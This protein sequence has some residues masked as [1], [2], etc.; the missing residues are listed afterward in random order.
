MT[1]LD[2]QDVSY[3]GGLAFSEYNDHSKWA[4][5]LESDWFCASDINRM[6]TQAARGG[7]ADCFE[8]AELATAM[9]N[10]VTSCDSC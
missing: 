2:I 8:N 3:P 5:G 9:R 6:T 10:A 7:A 1:V 4:V